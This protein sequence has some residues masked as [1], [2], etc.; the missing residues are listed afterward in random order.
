MD[1]TH[2]MIVSFRDAMKAFGD[3]VKWP[4]E[5]VEQALC[6]A[7]TETGSRRWGAYQDVCNNFKRRGMFYFAAHWLSSMYARS[8]QNQQGVLPD[9]R[10]N[11][12]GKSVGDESIQYRM[13]A[14]QDSYDDWLCTTIY[15]TRFFGLRKRAG[16]GAMAV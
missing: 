11:V 8:A 5:V 15:G 10:L 14:L 16:M 12:I 1:I 6:E 2:D 3:T 9:A 4:D 13:T 7:D